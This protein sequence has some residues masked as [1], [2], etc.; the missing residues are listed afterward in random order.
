MV[1]IT[2]R[3]QTRR[4]EYERIR[5]KPFTR[6]HGKPSRSDDDLLVEE[7]K[8]V[9]VTV[10]IPAYETWADKYGLLAEVIGDTEYQAK[11]GLTYVEPTKPADYDPGIRTDHTDLTKARREAEWETKKESYAVVEGARQG[12]CANIRDALDKQFHEQLADTDL[13]Y[14]EVTIEDYLKHLT[15]Q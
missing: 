14:G 11:T 7:I 15:E 2:S 5:E 3:E 8:K 13:G 6:I 1:K 12:I 4:T 9:A 10:Q